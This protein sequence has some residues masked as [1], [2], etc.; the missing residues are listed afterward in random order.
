MKAFVLAEPGKVQWYNAPEPELTPYGAILVPIAVT[1]CSSDVHTVFGGGSPKQPN[2]VLGHESI[3]RVVAVGEYVKDF[4]IGDKV[5]V[6]AITPDW[7]E[8]SIQ[9][10]NDRHASIRANSTRS[11]F[12]TVFN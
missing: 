11:F 6:P 4:K 12:R 9:E 1:P 5:A 8:K 3:G 2:L 10:G 7:R